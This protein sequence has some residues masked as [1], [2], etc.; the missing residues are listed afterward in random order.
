MRNNEASLQANDLALNIACAKGRDKLSVEILL[1]RMTVA[2]HH[3]AK[4][5]SFYIDFIKL[6]S[7]RMV[8]LFRV[9]L[10]C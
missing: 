5:L 2:A 8:I 4:N 1:A 7:F 10:F 9:K 3:L 6:S